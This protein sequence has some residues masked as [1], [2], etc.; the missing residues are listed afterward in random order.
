MKITHKTLPGRL[1]GYEDNVKC[2][3]TWQTRAEHRVMRPRSV[4]AFLRNL[5]CGHNPTLL[6]KL[7]L[8]NENAQNANEHCTENCSLRGHNLIKKNF[9]MD[10]VNVATNCVIE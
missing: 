10:S 1:T 5:S 4:D 2:M 8:Q 6:P 3:Q 7:V 9:A